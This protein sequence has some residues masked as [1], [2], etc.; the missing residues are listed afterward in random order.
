MDN[1]KV[2]EAKN[3]A[4]EIGLKLYC[5]ACE[6]YVPAIEI[7]PG[8]RHDEDCGGCGCYIK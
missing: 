5:W 8:G 4:E 1:E 2:I 6:K 3:D 7:T